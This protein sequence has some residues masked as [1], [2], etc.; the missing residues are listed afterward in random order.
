MGSSSEFASESNP[1]HVSD[2]SDIDPDYE[3]DMNVIKK[4]RLKH[5]LLIVL[6]ILKI[7]VYQVIIISS[8]WV[9]YGQ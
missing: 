1:Y 2:D 5:Y 3:L 9:K 8:R 4:L 7:I 6:Q